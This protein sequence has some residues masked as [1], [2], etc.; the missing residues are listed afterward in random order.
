M[1]VAPGF[2]QWL[3]L[4]EESSYGVYNSG[5]TSIWVRLAGDDAFTPSKVPARTIIRSADASNRRLQVLAGRYAISAG[6]KTPFYP[7]QAGSWLS[8]ATALSGTPLNGTSWT[9]TYFDGIVYRQYLGGVLQQFDLDSQA[10]RQE[11]E[12]STQW[13]FQTV[14]DTGSLA[15]PAITVF[16]SESPYLHTELGGRFTLSGTP[17]TQF[18]SF[19]MSVKNMWTA[20][21]YEQAYISFA[22]WSGRDIDLSSHL[23]YVDT[24]WRADY[25][26]QTALTFV[27]EFYRSS[28]R[29]CTLTFET[30]AFLSDRPVQHPLGG[31]LEQ[32]I[33]GQVFLDPTQSTPTD[34]AFTASF[35]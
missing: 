21:F 27:A 13:L 1:P 20:K 23:T 34:F 6:L 28:T 16:P 29:S 17:I 11:A 12:L 31:V 30:A 32:G 22:Q 10:D 18:D 7:S 15:Q 24:S 8:A 3:Q 9:A 2:Y 14:N 4:T 33:T 25:E 26:A 19:H 5:G 35:S